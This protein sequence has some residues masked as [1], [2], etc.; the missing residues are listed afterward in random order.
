MSDEEGAE[1]SM[2]L[3]LIGDFERIS[4]HSVNVVESAEELHEKK[5]EFSDEAKGELDMLF[6]ATS[7]IL[8]L[9]TRTFVDNDA[10][11]AQ[12]VEPLETVIDTLKSRM[13][14]SHIDRLQDGGCTIEA[15]FVWSDLITNIERTSDHCSNIALYVIDA[16]AHNLNVHESVRIIKKE[17]PYF[18][19]EYEAYLKKYTKQ[20]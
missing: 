4:D 18:Q 15:G 1:V 3:K 10:V 9:S 5:M 16:A 13:R 6:E 7:E 20:D 17:S 12:R 11:A 8:D 2:L 19:Q 14:N